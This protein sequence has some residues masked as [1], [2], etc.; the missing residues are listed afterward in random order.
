MGG[1]GGGNMGPPQGNVTT[2]LKDP[3]QSNDPRVNGMAAQFD[4]MDFGK[5]KKRRGRNRG[6]ARSNPFVQQGGMC[7]MLVG[8]DRR[9]LMFLIFLVC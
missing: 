8:P 6:D 5:K 9:R 2:N 1:G 3:S 4:S 7:W